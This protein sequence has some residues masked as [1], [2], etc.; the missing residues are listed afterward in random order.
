MNELA[1][2]FE[3]YHYIALPNPSPYCHSSGDVVT[4]LRALL[5]VDGPP[6][7]DLALSKAIRE[8]EVAHGLPSSGVI[9]EAKWQ[10]L[11][12]EQPEPEPEPA[13]K[14]RKSTSRRKKKGES[15]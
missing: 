11:V 8:W 10:T 9:T 12:A 6:E 1:W 14:A 13:P 5:G 3:R 4:T 2:P 7:V 15:T